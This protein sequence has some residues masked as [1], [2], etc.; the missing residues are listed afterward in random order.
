MTDT[1]F[2]K[3]RINN[4]TIDSQHYQLFNILQ[5]IINCYHGVY[6]KK[7]ITALMNEFL[8][9]TESHFKY[10][11]ELMDLSFYNVHCVT[12]YEE[13]ILEH[14][15]TISEIKSFLLRQKVKFPEEFPVE[16]ISKILVD[17]I[18]GYDKKFVDWL[19]LHKNAFDL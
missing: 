10:E 3:Y 14:R 6:D 2:K 7:V 15:Y 11:K 4:D 19:N 12:D 13:H 8:K 9:L 5:S 16:V 18:L 1:E 17:H